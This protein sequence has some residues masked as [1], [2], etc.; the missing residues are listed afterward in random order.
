MSDLS[1]WGTVDKSRFALV[2]AAPFTAS[3]YNE[4]LFRAPRK[5]LV[6]QSAKAFG[7]QVSDDGRYRI[8]CLEE[9][10]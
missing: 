2:E 6:A 10:A 7:Y 1:Q 9:A 4:I 3:G 5:W 8:I